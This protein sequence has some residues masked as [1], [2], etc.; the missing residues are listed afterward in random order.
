MEKGTRP[1]H[2]Q[3]SVPRVI[4]W[5]HSKGGTMKLAMVLSLSV[6]ALAA[7]SNA[8]ADVYNYNCT[9][10]GDS[11]TYQLQLSDLFASLTTTLGGTY[12]ASGTGTGEYQFD[13]PLQMGGTQMN[14]AM[15]TVSMG[16]MGAQTI[17][18]MISDSGDTG[19]FVQLD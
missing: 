6:L 11:E 10:A 1:D 5:K 16:E 9:V 12:T 2:L 18:P 7:A 15:L 13:Q 8:R 19:N 17:E 3:C 4:R 14:R